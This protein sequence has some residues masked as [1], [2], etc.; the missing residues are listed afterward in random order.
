MFEGES[1]EENYESGIILRSTRYYNDEK[2][3]Q[4]DTIDVHLRVDNI[5][6]P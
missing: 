2:E 6:S 1:P 3:K 4:M 5:F